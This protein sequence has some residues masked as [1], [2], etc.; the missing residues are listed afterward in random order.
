MKILSTNVYMG[1][2]LYAHFPV[3]R[4]QV[5]IGV[6]EDW[7]SVRLGAAFTDALLEALPGLADHGC[8][9]G[10]PGGFLRRLREDEGTWMAHTWEH[11][12]LELQNMAGSSVTFGR[13][14][15]NGPSGQYNLVFQYHQRDVGLEAARIAH[16]L[17]LSLLPQELN[18]GL[19]DEMDDG[20]DFEQD[21]DS[22]IR[23]AQRKELGPSTASLVRAA[24]ERE[25]PF[26]R[27]NQYSLVQF[28]H[29]KYQQRIQATITSKTPHIAVEIS[30]DKEDTHNLLKDLGLPVPR[31]HMVRSERDCV[32]AARRIGFSVVVKPLDAN[33]GRGVSI[34]LTEDE[35]VAIA[36]AKALENARGRSVLVESFVEGFDH[37][38]LVVNGELVAV[39][40]RVPGHVTGDGRQSIEQLIEEVNSD[41]RRGIGHEKVLTRLELDDQAIRLMSN[42]GLIQLDHISG[43]QALAMGVED[44]ARPATSWVRFML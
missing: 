41:P 10:E 18:A 38:M 44:M 4:H 2:S 22:F 16:Q 3:I 39:A 19:A 37:R 7:P 5:D 30:C 32:R 40:K 12:T 24:E 6:L 21:R 29:G 23:F 27:L 42:A 13:T 14:R 9:Y 11:A 35:Q 34:N 1:P 25:I 36:H 28:G 17:L 26:Q 8:S 33:H 43:N 31:Q 15:S 20:F